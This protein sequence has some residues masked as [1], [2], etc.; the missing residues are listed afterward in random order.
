MGLDWQ[1]VNKFDGFFDYWYE[2][3]CHEHITIFEDLTNK[4]P[5]VDTIFNILHKNVNIFDQDVLVIWIVSN[6]LNEE[7]VALFEDSKI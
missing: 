6:E 5:C 7:D 3:I 1:D 4:F 2:V